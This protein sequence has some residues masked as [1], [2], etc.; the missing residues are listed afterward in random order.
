MLKQLFALVRGHSHEAA[1]EH[2]RSQCAGHIAPADSRLRRCDR[3]RAP[4]DCRRHRPERSGDPAI[5]E[6]GRAHRRPG[7]PHRHRARAGAE[8]TC[9]RSG[10]D[11]RADGSGTDRVGRRA[12]KFRHGDRTPQADRPRFRNA[13]ARPAARPAH[14]GG[15]R[16]GPI[17]CARPHR[18]PTFRRSRTPRKRCRGFAYGKGRWTPPPSAI[19]EME[20]SGDPAAVSRKTGGSRLWRAARH[21]RRRRPRTAGEESPA[22]QPEI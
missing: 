17:V 5:Q 13:A 9:P 10:R 22:T 4:G 12:E 16:T 20:Q 7:K 11:H 21:Q 19:A 18:A 14:R 15:R 8:R 1:Q 2:S 3:R 6:A